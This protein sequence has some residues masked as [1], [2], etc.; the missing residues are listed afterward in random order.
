MASISAV[1]LDDKAL[2][3]NYN[4]EERLVEALSRIDERIDLDWHEPII[5]FS[6][7]KAALKRSD[8]TYDIVFI[9]A[10]WPR[11]D[12]KDTGDQVDELIR[13][14]RAHDGSL[15][16][17]I[18]RD[19]RELF[20]NWYAED[21]QSRPHA[22]LSKES[23]SNARILATLLEGG[24]SL[25]QSR[26]R[27]RLMVSE[28]QRADDWHRLPDHVIQVAAEEVLAR[29]QPGCVRATFKPLGGGLSGAA[30]ILA[31]A[32][33]ESGGDELRAGYL[34]KVDAD[35][36][37][38]ISEARA[39]QTLVRSW[40]AA[41]FASLAGTA[42]YG[43]L[44]GLAF[45]QAWGD[46]A[47]SNIERFLT[48][49][50]WKM[51]FSRSIAQAQAS[52]SARTDDAVAEV[53]QLGALKG[54]RL[55][56]FVSAWHALGLRA[57]GPL[58]VGKAL[59]KLRSAR[60]TVLTIQHC[61]LHTRNVLVTR[62][63]AVVLVDAASMRQR[64][65]W[66]SDLARFA[67]WVA[68][69]FSESK[70]GTVNDLVFGLHTAGTTPAPSPKSHWSSKL[71]MRLSDSL[72]LLSECYR[73]RA[74]AVE[75]TRDWRAAVMAELMRA[76]YSSDWFGPQARTLAAQAADSVGRSLLAVR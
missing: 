30:T 48:A 59:D 18:S 9:D 31:E 8:L 62:E 7:A 25:L 15:V 54:D 4:L 71:N 10:L 36:G 17:L 13:A 16:V 35:R 32:T 58:A 51:V 52:S 5:E 55:P 46:T 21:A 69:A 68:V 49:R 67:V 70:G 6:K 56:R 2:T 76:T 29:V 24:F 14:A 20:T 22:I 28:W 33:Y 38:T 50:L 64:E 42:S 61:D 37:R 74:L 45:N 41:V 26:L 66:C 72:A 73:D 1:L 34:L 57:S 44:W 11:W 65:F 39:H 53:L 63:G 75:F 60:G 19:D 43:G 12:D 23:I 27:S 47:E 40:P 3:E